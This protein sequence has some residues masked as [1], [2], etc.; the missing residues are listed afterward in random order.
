MA[1]TTITENPTFNEMTPEQLREAL[2]S[3]R[4]KEARLEADLAIK[5]HPELEAEITPIVLALTQ[6]KVCDKELTASIDVSGQKELKAVEAQLIYFKRRVREL[7]QVREKL[8]A[9]SKSARLEERRE[10]C[11]EELNDILMASVPKFEAVGV[12]IHQIVPSLEDFD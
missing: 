2:R 3:L 11:A 9:S 8:I 4:D 10:S 6:L 1:G 5:E 7:E 12:S